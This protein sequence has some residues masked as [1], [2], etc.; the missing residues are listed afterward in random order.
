MCQIEN[1]LMW[2]FPGSSPEHLEKDHLTWQPTLTNQCQSFLAVPLINQ[3]P[4]LGRRLEI[5]VFLRSLISS[6]V[7]LLGTCFWDGWLASALAKLFH[8]FCQINKAVFELSA[9]THLPEECC[10][11][12]LVQQVSSMLPARLVDPDGL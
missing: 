6:S 1:F 3:R 2:L 10:C 5:E 11:H 4:V 7:S 9:V 12:K 8:W